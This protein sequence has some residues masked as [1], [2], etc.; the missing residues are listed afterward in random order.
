VSEIIK[1]ADVFIGVSGPGTLKK[2]DVKNMNTK[3]IIFALANPDPEI[4]LDDAL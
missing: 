3:P 2:E 1:G 4:T